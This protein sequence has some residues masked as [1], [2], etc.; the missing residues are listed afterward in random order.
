MVRVNVNKK[1]NQ[2]EKKVSQKID[3]M[4]MKNLEELNHKI[5]E[6]FTPYSEQMQELVMEVYG[7]PYM[8]IDQ[9]EYYSERMSEL[10]EPFKQDNRDDI[11]LQFSEEVVRKNKTILKES[12]D[13]MLNE[14]SKIGIPYQR[15]VLEHK[16]VFNSAVSR[17]QRYLSMN[18]KE[19]CDELKAICGFCLDSMID[20][21]NSSR[22]IEDDFEIEEIEIEEVVSNNRLIR[23]DNVHDIIDLAISNGFREERITGSHHIYKHSNGQILV[24]PVHNKTINVGLAYGLQ[25]Q[26]YEKVC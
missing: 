23:T 20:Y 11:L 10:I 2:I 13:E 25:K 7:H 6:Y 26:I 1:I 18:Y 17:M 16:K 9:F 19:I 4:T 12:I 24:I 8:T 3:E 22:V 14:F 15:A 21:S 5:Y